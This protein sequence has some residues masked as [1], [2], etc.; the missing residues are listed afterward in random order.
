[1]SQ[2]HSAEGGMEDTL[3]PNQSH[4]TEGI[5][6]DTF[7]PNQSYSAVGVMEDT[8]SPSECEKS[9]N[10]FVCETPL[11]NF[12]HLTSNDTN[13]NLTNSFDSNK[14]QR[15]KEYIQ[16]YHSELGLDYNDG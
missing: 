6:G 5:M 11:S 7:S 2:S 1:M 10:D 15:I 13:L 3:S 9:F 8:F 4:S 12:Y 16:K 14:Y